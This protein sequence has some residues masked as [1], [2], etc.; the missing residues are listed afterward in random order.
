VSVQTS[1]PVRRAQTRD[2][3]WE[4]TESRELPELSEPAASV[5]RS[6]QLRASRSRVLGGLDDLLAISVNHLPDLD[7]FARVFL[8]FLEREKSQIASAE[9]MTL[10]FVRGFD[11]HIEEARELLVGRRPAAFG[12]RVLDTIGGSR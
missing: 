1:R 6:A 8:P 12:D 11:R 9:Q 2:A 3:S 4:L 5:E 10:G 7:R